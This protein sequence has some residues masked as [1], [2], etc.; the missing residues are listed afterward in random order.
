M[1]RPLTTVA[2]IRTVSE[3]RAASRQANAVVSTA[4]AVPSATDVHR[5]ARK[6]SIQNSTRWPSAS[7]SGNPGGNRAENTVPP[8]VP[9]MRPQSPSANGP[10]DRVV[11]GVVGAGEEQ[12][13][14]QVH[15]PGPQHERQHPDGEQQAE[16]DPALPARGGLGRCGAGRVGAQLRR[17]LHRPL[18][19][20]CDARAGYP[21]RRPRLTVPLGLR[22]GPRAHVGR[23]E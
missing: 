21:R 22:L 11:P 7:T 10:G 16:A 12:R 4:P 13:W 8:V 19:I 23:A 9:G 17:G 5:W 20:G 15:V 14:V 2:T 6:G 3:A 18:P 1:T